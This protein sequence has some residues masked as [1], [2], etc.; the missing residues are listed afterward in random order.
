MT[1]FFTATQEVSQGR[2]RFSNGGRRAHTLVRAVVHC[3]LLL[4]PLHV[5]HVRAEP[6][7]RVRAESR[8]EII[9]ERIDPAWSDQLEA[10]LLA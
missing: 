3:V 2:L 9:S 8:I 4:L 5:A 10:C 7:V 6:K 1:D